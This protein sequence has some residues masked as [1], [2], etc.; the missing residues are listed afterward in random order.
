[1]AQ[2]DVHLE[3]EFNTGSVDAPGGRL[4]SYDDREIPFDLAVVVP[5]HAGAP[6]VGRSDGLG[7]ELNFVPVDPA[8][9]QAKVTPCVFAFGDAA[10]VPTSKAGSATHF[11]GE[12]VAENVRHYLHGE[13]LS[14]AYDGHANCFI[15]TG[16]HRALMIDFN[17]D[18]E[19]LPGRYPGRLGLPLL[20]PS[21]ANHVGKLLFERLY[22]HALLPGRDVPGITAAMPTAGKHPPKFDVS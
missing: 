20:R 17:Y 3:T 11:Q 14:A 9:L 6:Y 5:L 7:D 2:R 22:W 8:T 13:P 10:D 16:F 19:P 12:V 15:E 21:R 18:T 4:V 1:L